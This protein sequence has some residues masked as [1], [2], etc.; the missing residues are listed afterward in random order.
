M[1]SRGVLVYRCRQCGIIVDDIVV[2]D[3]ISAVASIVA[4]GRT[5]RDWPIVARMTVLHLC[6]AGLVGVADLICGR[7][8]GLSPL[9][10]PPKRET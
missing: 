5:P 3:V 10:G 8:D 1:T 7:P 2:P 9:P 6:G 4:K